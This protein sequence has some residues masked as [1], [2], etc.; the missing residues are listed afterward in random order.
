MTTIPCCFEEIF[1]FYSVFSFSICLLQR[2]LLKTAPRC[3]LESALGPGA[4]EPV[5]GGEVAGEVRQRADGEAAL[6]AHLS[7]ALE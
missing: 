1:H 4:V 2:V 5:L 3:E 6:G 7:I